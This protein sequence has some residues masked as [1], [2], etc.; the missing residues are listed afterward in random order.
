MYLYLNGG[1][2]VGLK[3]NP[4]QNVNDISITQKIMLKFPPR[5]Q[6]I[7]YASE[8]YYK[9]DTNGIDKKKLYDIEAELQTAY[10]IIR[11][12]PLRTELPLP[13]PRQEVIPSVP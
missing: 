7:F 4:R 6:D 10:K 3:L 2:E 13:L 11:P 9:N 8:P 12:V 1:H 5:Q